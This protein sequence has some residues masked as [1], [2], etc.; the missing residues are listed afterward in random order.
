MRF[1]FDLFRGLVPR[2]NPRLLDHH[3]AQVASN[4]RLSR[5]SFRPW[6][7]PLLVATLER[8]GPLK[9]LYRFEDE[10]LAWRDVVHV[11]RGPVDNTERKYLYWTGDTMQDQAGRGADSLKP[12]ITDDTIA[13]GEA[14]VLPIASYNLGVPRPS[15]AVTVAEI[16]DT[17]SGTVTDAGGEDNGLG[18]FS[19]VTDRSVELNQYVHEIQSDGTTI[20]GSVTFSLQ[21]TAE[22]AASGT[23]ACTVA[24]LVPGAD[25][26]VPLGSKATATIELDGSPGEPD[27]A[28]ASVTISFEDTPPE[29][30]HEY[31]FSI[32]ESITVDNIILTLTGTLG[33]EGTVRVDVDTDTKATGTIDIG[34]AVPL[35]DETVT[36]G[37]KVYRF[38]TAGA[39]LAAENDVLIGADVEAT[40]DNLVEAIIDGTGS[41]TVYHASTEANEDVTATANEDDTAIVDLEAIEAGFAGNDIALDVDASLVTIS[42]T[43]L[44][45]AVLG[46]SVDDRVLFEGVGGMTD[47]NQELLVVG[48][49]EAEGFITV[50]LQT[51]QEYL[52]GGTWARTFEADSEGAISRIWTY[53]W[54][55]KMGDLEMEGPPAV[56]SNILTTALDAPIQL[57]GIDTTPPDNHNITHARIYR[58]SEGQLLFIEEV[59]LA[60]LEDDSYTDTTP[61]TE[62]GEP[63]PSI[64]WEPPPV[65]M[66]SL[67][68]MPNG[69]MAGLLGT[70]VLFCVPYR[71]HAWPTRLRYS[72]SHQAVS[73]ATFGSTLVV[74]TTEKPYRFTG[75]EP[76]NISQDK[77]EVAHAC[78]SARGMVDMG[79]SII[80]PGPIGLVEAS[81]SGFQLLTAVG[82]P[83]GRG[84]YTR[85]EWNALDPTTIIGAKYDDRYI[86]LHD[87]GD[88]Q[89][90]F[91]LHHRDPYNSLTSLTLTCDAFFTD[92]ENGA[93]YYTVDN[94]DQEV[95]QFDGHATTA[96]NGVW[97][98]KEFASRRPVGLSAAV[99]QGSEYPV[100]FRLYG[101]GVLRHTETVVNGNIFRLPDGYAAEVVEFEIEGGEGIHTLDVAESVEELGR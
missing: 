1:R 10:W 96:M 70:E 97:R 22:S 99:V 45:G 86:A 43:T 6:R 74:T 39:G 83:D 58:S 98:S 95:Y 75:S 42:G 52:G 78:V 15:T 50:S 4:L 41:G 73:C 21:L 55:A 23:V 89:T 69:M 87:P 19:D 94:G 76:D 77:G 91:V 85:D 27:L 67:T 28:L 100:T 33:G 92:D 63:C 101:D 88:G 37:A 46:L 24:R 3:Q 20:T 2:L 65:G 47:L 53:T 14:D 30:T 34:A 7:S 84:I 62:L 51:S 49:N 68:E 5:G 11:A 56:S 72:V 90:A 12:Q 9:T 40:R 71:P 79:S 57:T 17:V 64:D 29:G 36:V 16:A 44:D 35:N 61:S 25:P 31:M 81:P 54:V 48:V 93:L 13:L 32:G 66:H 80:Y 18:P 26:A 82:G 8:D 60:A 38:R 59:A